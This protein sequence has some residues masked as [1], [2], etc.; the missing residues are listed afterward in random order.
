VKAYC[1]FLELASSNLT[2]HILTRM[3]PFA[4]SCKKTGKLWTGRLSKD[5]EDQPLCSEEAQ[6]HAIRLLEKQKDGKL[7]LKFEDARGFKVDELDHMFALFKYVEIENLAIMLPGLQVGE[8]TVS[9]NSFCGHQHDEDTLKNGFCINFKTG[10]IYLSSYYHRVTD[11]D[12][13]HFSLCA[14]CMNK[15]YLNFKKYLD[16]FKAQYPE[17][18]VLL[19]VDFNINNIFED[20]DVLAAK[21]FLLGHLELKNHEEVIAF[22]EEKIKQNDSR[23]KDAALQYKQKNTEKLSQQ[24]ILLYEKMKPFFEKV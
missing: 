19:E 1:D 18:F 15:Y 14:T 11:T 2:S 21:N 12:K 4:A 17:L 6:N 10:K 9:Y 13:L 3:D 7:F 5:L 22:L 16:L 20:I 23:L 24:D 8:K